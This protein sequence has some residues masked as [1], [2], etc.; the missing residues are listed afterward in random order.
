MKKM[1][2]KLAGAAFAIA[3][4]ALGF[5]NGAYYAETK[6]ETAAEITALSDE[7]LV[8]L[9]AADEWGSDLQVVVQPCGD[10]DFIAYIVY[11]Q[12]GA[13]KYVGKSN[14]DWLQRT[15]GVK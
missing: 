13:V 5:V 14:R 3:I 11:D 7:E 6:T 9:K 2:L 15:Y 1:L 10:E 4:Y 8:Q 12:E